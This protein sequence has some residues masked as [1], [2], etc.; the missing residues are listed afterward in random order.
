MRSDQ[1]RSM[2][3]RLIHAELPPTTERIAL[4]LVLRL[5]A[6]TGVV[7]LTWDQY[8]ALTL[9]DSQGA[10]RRHLIKLK[11]AGLIRYYAGDEVVVRFLHWTTAPISPRA[12]AA[13]NPRPGSLAEGLYV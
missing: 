9:N 13:V 3:E 5:D 10:A 1:L 8:L 12:Y 2:I 6:D 7:S 4:R 11:Q